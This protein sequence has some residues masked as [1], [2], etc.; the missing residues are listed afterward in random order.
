M[1]RTLFHKKSQQPGHGTWQINKTAERRLLA[2]EMDFW[3]MSAGKLKLE[4]I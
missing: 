4:I 2:L 3:Q 1:L